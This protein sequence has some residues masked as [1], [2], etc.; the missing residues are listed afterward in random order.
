M[1]WLI[2]ILLISVTSEM[3]SRRHTAVPLRIRDLSRANTCMCLAKRLTQFTIYA[4][5]L[6]RVRNWGLLQFSD[7]HVGLCKAEFVS[8][9]VYIYINFNDCQI[10]DKRLKNKFQK[11]SQEFRF[12]EHFPNLYSRLFAKTIIIE[13][14]EV[15]PQ[16]MWKT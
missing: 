2:G 1:H 12:N 13:V 15:V 7:F 5:P 10:N 16:M 3:V 6:F 8:Q 14:K 11:K 4:K 9:R